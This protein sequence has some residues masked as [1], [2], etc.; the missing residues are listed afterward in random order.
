MQNPEKQLKETLRAIYT[1]YLYIGC[2]S[3]GNP[4]YFRAWKKIFRTV[5]AKFT[6]IREII[7]RKYAET[8]LH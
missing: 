4:P 1:R 7:L 6:R 3:C 2:P 5:K 8:K